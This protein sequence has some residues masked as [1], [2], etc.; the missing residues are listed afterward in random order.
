MSNKI[1]VPM[2][3]VMRVTVRGQ[4]SD[5]VSNSPET[6]RMDFIRPLRKVKLE[7][8]LTHSQDLGFLAQGQGHNQG[9]KINL[10]GLQH[11]YF[12]L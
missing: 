5:S 11:L 12:I 8:N 9:S 4:R 10:K 6:A 2:H 1:K 3:K 7:K